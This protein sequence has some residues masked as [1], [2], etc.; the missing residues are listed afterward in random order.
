MGEV[1]LGR[2]RRP[3]SRRLADATYQARYVVFLTMPQY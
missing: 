2:A 1:A 3:I